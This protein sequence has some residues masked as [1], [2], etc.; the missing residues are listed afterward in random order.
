[1]YKQTYKGIFTPHHP[2]KYKGNSSNIIYRS[3]WELR[4][5]N[6][7]DKN[8]SILEWNSEEVIIPYR[9]PIDGKTH[10]YYVDFYCKL[11]NKNGIVEKI[12][13]EIKPKKFCRQPK[14]PKNKRSRKGY[15]NE[16]K[17]W[18]INTAKWDAAKAWSKKNGMKFVILTEDTLT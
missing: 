8:N 7:C 2:R 15:L 13:V 17:Q 5:M 12:L 11:K 3:S 16:L 14:Q 1:M 18:G 9:S 10:R 4:F 6:Y